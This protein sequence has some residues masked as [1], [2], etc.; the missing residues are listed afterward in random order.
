M[1]KDDTQGFV[2]KTRHLPKAREI[3]AAIRNFSPA[4]KTAFF[5]FAALLCAGS[6]FSL[7]KLSD[8][9]SVTVPAR[10]GTLTE[11]MVGAPR[12]VNPLLA[13]SDTDR[14]LTA[15]VYSGLLKATPG[16]TL[17]PDLAESYAI[18]P[19]G[20]TYTFTLKKNAAFSD[21]TPVTADD[22]AFTIRE[23]EDP[24]LKSPRRA[25]WDGVTVTKINDREVA[26]TLKQP[27]APFL[28]NATMGILPARL[29]RGTDPEQFPFSVY[30]A[31]PV[32]SG[33]YRV[34]SVERTADGTP[35]S[36]RLVPSDHYA[37]GAPY[38]ANLV[39]RFY[40]SADDCLAAYRNREVDSLSAVSPEEA[41]VLKD[42]GARVE[43]AP[44]PR[45]FAAF[46]NQGQAPVLSRAEVRQALE[47]AVDKQRIVDTVL[48][49]YGIPI[50]GPIPPELLDDA[51]QNSATTTLSDR[52]AAAK[53]VLTDNG[54]KWNA[55]DGVMEKKLD[56][57]TTLSLSFSLSTSDTPELKQAA[58]MIRDMWNAIGAKVSVKV[59]GAGDLSQ[60]VIRA[61]KYDALFFGEIVGRDLD[62]FAF[63]DSSQRNDPGLNVA[64]Y[65]NS[66]AD[67]LL[68]DARTDASKEQRIK[69]Y[70]KFEQLV[71]ADIPAVF[72]YSPDF[73]YVLPKELRGVSLENIAV[74]AER[75]LGVS[76]WY[77][78]TDRVWTFL[79]PAA[80]SV[81]SEN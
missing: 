19:D 35:I 69:L 81:P 21:G 25:N 37:G 53:K 1:N 44:L 5:F 4:E 77:L 50:D 46:F 2:R 3:E 68:E 76:N 57:K 74:P 39:F 54:W 63:W 61:R 55:A 6:A 23:A 28:E 79:A 70:R 78:K 62:L 80:A 56:K 9:L 32:G 41:V 29:W 33:P 66:K 49:G 60:N 8:A 34:A 48:A 58:E 13:F 43:H 17:V 71:A 64:L 45:V 31:E 12:F 22:V 73:L 15:L 38:I 18:S 40:P 11:G 42:E 30:N 26:F 7:F 27:Y 47:L 59:F 24:L 67:K 75:F 16:G 10:G 72:V 52:A 51:D 65:A 36:Y 14:D 20:L